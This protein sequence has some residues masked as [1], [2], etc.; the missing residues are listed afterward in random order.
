MKGIWTIVGIG[1]G[2][3]LMYFLDP[4]RGNRRRALVRDKAL[5]LNRRTRETIEG[6]M[7]DL[8]NRTKGLIHEAK[9]MFGDKDR[10]DSGSSFSGQQPLDDFS[11]GRGI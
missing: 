10:E 5:S 1:A 8:G 4:D 6:R 2:A 11:S 3:A 9:G 7:E